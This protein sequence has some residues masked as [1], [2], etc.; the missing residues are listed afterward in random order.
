MPKF[1]RRL[2]QSRRTAHLEFA[3]IEVVGALLPPEIITRTATFDMPEQAEESYGLLPGLKLRDEIARYYRVAMAHWDRFITARDGHIRAPKA[4]MLDLLRDCFGFAAVR[5]AGTV[6]ISERQFPIRHASHGGRVPVVLAPLA[7]AGSRKSGIDEALPR[8]GEDARRRSATQLLQD[9][10]NAADDALWGIVSDGCTLRLMRDNASLTRP[11]WIE[12]DLE[13]I[14]TEGLFADF[15]ALWSLIHTSRFGA[16]DSAPSDCPLERWRERGRIEG[17]AAKEKLRLGVEAALLELGCGFLEE[18]ANAD[19]RGAL[20]TGELTRQEY[21]EE[22][23][24]LVYRLIFLFAAED[25]DLLHSPNAPTTARA[26]YRD[27]YSVGRLRDRCT[28]NAALDRHRDAWEGLR[29]LFSALSNGVPE[30]GLVAL[31]GLFTSSNIA[32]LT[33]ARITNRRLL[34]AIWH[35][36]WFRPDGQPMTRV[37]WR[38]MQTEE[39]GSVYESL[40]ELI[41]IVHLETR[42]FAFTY[43]DAANRGN[44]RKTT[45]SYYTPDSLVQLLLATTLDPVLDAAEARNPTDPAPEILKLSFIDPAC[46]SGHFLLGAARRAA[47]RIARNRLSGAPSQE[48]FQHALR[49]VVSNCIFGV[50]RNPMAVELCKVALWIEALE[51]GKPL[52]FLDA[53]IRCGDSLVG[54]FDYQMLINGLPDEAFEPLTGDDKAVAKAW[55]SSNR[56]QRDDMAIPGLFEELSAP[57]S[58]IDGAASVLAMPE[59]TIEQT[60]GKSRAWKRL[61]RD[62]KRTALK[63]AC[64]LYVAAFLLPKSSDVPNPDIDRRALPTT[65]AVW[66]MVFT[67]DGG[68][69]LPSKWTEI[70]ERNRVFHWPLEFPAVMA[71][72][73]FDAVV[74]NPPWERIKLQE[75]EFFAA[76][77]DEIATAP[78]KAERDKRI[79]ELKKAEPGTPQARLSEAFESAKRAAESA[80]VFVRK[81][82]RFPLAG[83]GDVNTYALFAEHFSRLARTT[84]SVESG[85]YSAQAI[86]TGGVRRLPPGRA[87]VIVPTSIATDS[88]ASAFF[89]D[90]VTRNRLA[91]L[92][93]FYE[94]RKWFKDTDER[95]PF[96]IFIVADHRGSIPVVFNIQKIDEVHEKERQ[97]FLGEEDFK[98]FNPNTLTAPLFR[99]RVD[100]ELTHKLYRVL[101]VL[102]RERPGHPVGD[103][104]PWGITFQTLFH[105]SN[106][107]GYFQTAEQLNV[108]GFQRDARDWRHEDGQHYVPLFEAKMI[109]HFDHRFG[110]YAGLKG[111]PGDG[112]LPEAPAAAKAGPDYETEPWYWVPADETALRVARVPTRL[113]QYFRKENAEGCLKVLAE[114][115]LGTLDPEELGLANLARTARLG[116][117][118]LRD[119]LGMRALERS[120][121]GARVASWLAKAAPGARKMQRETPLS[122]ENIA[123]IQEAPSDPLELTGALIDHKQPRWLLGWRNITNSTS[124]R[125]VIAAVFP[126][127]GVGHSAPIMF[128]ELKA[129][130]IATLVAQ[131]S[132]VTLDYAARQKLAGTNLTY[133]YLE[134]FPVLAPDRL[135]AGDYA[136]ITPRVLELTY[137]SHSMRL[138]AEDLGHTGAPFAFDPNRRAHL[139]A[140]LDAFFARKYGLTRDELRYILDPGDIH[141]PDYPSETFRV[142][143][144]DEIKRFGEYR[145]QRLVLAAFDRLTGV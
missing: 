53:R 114:W 22:L 124:E 79:K 131:L 45:G 13:K 63:K 112:S 137:T 54:V 40:L 130:Q 3:G 135:N 64:D 35:L 110:S 132:S 145:T 72:G 82:G 28:R 119:V 78:N 89:G 41:P 134:Q 48:A 8:F 42:S 136:F 80:S 74:G 113:K 33:A 4:F 93:S 25:R 29:A 34:K 52:S 118:R 26:T 16:A 55:K 59:D 102:I 76:L 87:G 125:T 88:S 18:P 51:P 12:A 36:S 139:Q 14:F 126:R 81:T 105:M 27:G 100:R 15:S 10:L 9:Y 62:P 77:D 20:Q 50:D 90:L 47:T 65:E 56:K 85:Q 121:V 17:S 11:A 61:L 91:G 101:P 116:E 141:G 32:D 6:V 99:A 120:I 107:S 103:E 98:L 111:R 115:V 128:T 49:E 19:L 39:L 86:G 58:I 122:E 104:N 84:E 23:L 140:E 70:T 60:K 106:D 92:Y 127:V 142:L 5:E 71:A 46:G 117:A 2:R 73:G 44:E 129:H 21:F 108:Q 24:R 1:V 30:L 43:G 95:K 133:S 7:P 143:K 97:I 69:D 31:G 109:H 38:D 123:F 144:Q 67:V 83:T 68:P 57:A 66:R 75:Q 138:W 94:V 96:C 37:N